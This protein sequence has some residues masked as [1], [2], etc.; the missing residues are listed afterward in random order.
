[1]MRFVLALFLLLTALGGPAEARLSER[2]LAALITPPLQLGTRDPSL[3]VWTLLDGGGAQLGYVFES[4][5]L[6][7][8]PGFSGTPINLLI[9]I[10]KAGTFVD[11]RLINQH[12]PV[13]VE[14]LGPAPL[15]EFLRQYAGKSLATNIK[16]GNNHDDSRDNSSNSYI[17][18]VSKATASVRIA[19]ETILAAALQVARE[20]LAGISPR[21]AARPRQDIFTPMDWQG[22]VAAGLIGHLRLTNRDIE[23]AFAGT[24]T[25][26]EDADPNGLF[27]ELWFADLGIP[28]IARSLLTEE[29]LRRVDRHVEPYE[30][31]ILIMADGPHAIVGENFVRNSVPDL[32]SMRQQGFPVNLRDADVELEFAPGVPRPGQ[33]MVLRVDTRL[34]FDPATSWT[35]AARVIRDRGILAGTAARDFPT[36][37]RAPAAYFALP[38]AEAATGPA[39]VASWQDHAGE[40]AVLAAALALLAVF[41]AYPRPLV[42][43]PRLFAWVRA[44]WLAFTVAIIGWYWQGQLSIIN[45]LAMVKAIRE[46]GSLSFFLY[47]PF[48]VML[49]AFVLVVTFVWGRGTFC[50][51]LCPFGALQEF[52]SHL[53]RLLRLREWRISPR[54]DR[55]LLWLKYGILAGLAAVA[56]TY[57]KATEYVA[58]VEPFKTAITLIFVRDWPYVAYAAAALALG[59]VVYKGYCRYV[60]PLGA[61]L[62]VIARLRRFDWIARRLECGTPC[63]LCAARCRYNAIGTAGA[64]DYA[65]CFQCLD[66]V[67][68]YSDARRCVPFV[69]ATKHASRTDAP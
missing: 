27:V 21:P 54:Q 36:D 11:V 62:A 12:E 59:L 26:H 53:G 67:S 50:G 56:L 3:P 32:L 55:R 43:R 25:V 57:P 9:A 5:D 66:C 14:G 35:L 17:D 47:D 42:S 29:G 33:A 15:M 69:L 22:L 41:L 24:P 37:Y 16:V 58:E 8:L 10:D 28:T 40:L 61:F 1:M 34:G 45:V 46:G 63:Q 20:R 60:C 2:D 30:E 48:T 19:N 51:W 39:W 7:P 68:I 13:F 64:V 6:A 65:E 23:S 4:A 38:N 52:V 49:G 31:P 44:G 18:G